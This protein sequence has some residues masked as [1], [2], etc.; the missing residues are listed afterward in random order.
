M[1]F[2][3]MHISLFD[4]PALFDKGMSLISEKRRAHIQK[5]INPIPARLSLGAGILLHIAMKEEGLLSHYDKIKYGEHGKPYLDSVPFHFSLSHSGQYA[6]CAYD[7]VPLG[8]D[9]QK[10]K[11]KLPAHLERILSEQEMKQLSTLEDSAKSD[12]FYKIWTRKESL[13]KYDGR[14][15]KISLQDITANDSICSFENKMLHFLDLNILQP[16]YAISI[17]SEKEII[18]EGIREITSNFLTKY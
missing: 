10:K 6:I 7:T 12:F 16:Y 18:L 9:I 4:D 11:E 3:Y 15:L 8:A 13:S 2:L 5:R 14:G 17:C 1:K